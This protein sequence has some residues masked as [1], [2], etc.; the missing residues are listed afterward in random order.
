[1]NKPTI[2]VTGA[3]GQLGSELKVLSATYTSYNFLFVTKDE[4]AIDDI[5]AVKKYFD[6]QKID[7]CINCAAYTAVDKAESEKERAFLINGEAV[8]NLAAV[9]KAHNTA[10]IHISTDYV[11]DGNATEPI[12]EDDPVDPIGVYG[13]SKLKGEQLAFENNSGTIVIRTSWVYSSFGNN[14]VKT[15]L[16]LM[17]ER[18][19]INVV[20]D[21]RGC[22]TYAAD[23]ADAIMQIIDKRSIFNAQYSIFNYSNS[24]NITWYDFAVAI[25]E[26]TGS[27]CVVNPI[28]T[29]QY[30]TPAKRP[31]YS[32]LDTSKIQQVFNVA[33]PEWKDSLQ[34][35]LF[36]LNTKG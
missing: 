16:R 22:P 8:G 11:F 29:S 3:N 26:L 20:N 14:F 2:L 12:K 30:P 5:D 34:K 23:L 33:V 21:Q 28:P 19:S 7:H 31:Q 6:L 15:M 27:K 25:K 17:K 9:C 4:L 18:E 36:L 24:G 10:F 35:C 13:A 1:L 32:V